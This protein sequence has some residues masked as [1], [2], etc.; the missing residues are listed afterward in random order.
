MTLVIVGQKIIMNLFVA[1]LLENFDEGVLKQ[2][3][4]DY[5]ETQRGVLENRGKAPKGLLGLLIAK[6][7]AADQ[8][9]QRKVTQCR[10]GI[11]TRAKT[12]RM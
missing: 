12:M 8:F 4:I 9:L 5:E 6:V 7:K 11:V 2:K 10:K 1:I 3:M